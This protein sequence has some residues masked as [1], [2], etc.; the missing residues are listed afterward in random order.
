MLRCATRDRDRLPCPLL[1]SHNLVSDALSS[2]MMIIAKSANALYTR[3]SVRRF[4]SDLRN[5]KIIPAQMQRTPMPSLRV[6]P[7]KEVLCLPK[8]G[9]RCDAIVKVVKVVANRV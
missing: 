2:Q 8:L 9:A 3:T 6:R 5:Q 1:K 7:S 4:A